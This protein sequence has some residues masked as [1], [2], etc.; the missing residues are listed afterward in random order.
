MQSL[1]N[2]LLYEG[3]TGDIER[4]FHEEGMLDA[5]TAAEHQPRKRYPGGSAAQSS[6]IH[7]LD[8]FLVRRS[9][10]RLPSIILISIGCQ[11][12]AYG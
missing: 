10:A 8:V 3:D 1:P 12:L 7:T 5:A 2:G 9:P 4:M 11:T 6:L